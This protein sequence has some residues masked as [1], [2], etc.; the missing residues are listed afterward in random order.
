MSAIEY[1]RERL[2]RRTYKPDTTAMAAGFAIT[3]PE[4]TNEFR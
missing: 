2:H 3:Q 4:V 1:K